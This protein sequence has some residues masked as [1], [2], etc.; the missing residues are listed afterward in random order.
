LNAGSDTR[1]L[2]AIVTTRPFPSA[3]IATK[4]AITT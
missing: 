1:N 3:S 2:G 4:N